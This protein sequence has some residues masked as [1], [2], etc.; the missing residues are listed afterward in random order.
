MVT[1][2]GVYWDSLQPC[3][4]PLVIGGV[5]YPYAINLTGSGTAAR[6]G[7]PVP[8]TT[9]QKGFEDLQFLEM[10]EARAGRREAICV[11]IRGLVH[12]AHVRGDG[13]VF[14]GYGHL[15]A[16]PAELVVD[17][18]MSV[19]IKRTPVYDYGRL[20]RDGTSFAR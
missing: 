9:D 14:G 16:L 5:R 4:P 15:G 19:S 10:R 2:S 3:R 11:V 8:F 20:L 17:R 6:E 18:V 7:M 13:R 12:A 1:M